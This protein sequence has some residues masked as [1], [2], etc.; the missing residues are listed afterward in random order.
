MLFVVHAI[1]RL[2]LTQDQHARIRD[3]SLE[4]SLVG[5]YSF[6][7]WPHRSVSAN[8]PFSRPCSFDDALFMATTSTGSAVS[9]Q[10]MYPH[11]SH[12][13]STSLHQS[14]ATVNQ[15]LPVQG[16]LSLSLALL[17]LLCMDIESD[18][19]HQSGSGL[20]LQLHGHGDGLC[21]PGWMFL[22]AACFHGQPLH[23]HQQCA[24][25]FWTHG[26]LLITVVRVMFF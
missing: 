8:L 18:S 4:A 7:R 16:S 9:L 5:L 10:H 20:G 22:V 1:G 12:M 24:G 11:L 3:T 17:G 13:V 25:D 6:L 26:V 14:R 23:S 15:I 19:R 2:R 21:T